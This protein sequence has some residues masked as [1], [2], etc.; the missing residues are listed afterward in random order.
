MGFTKPREP[1]H[2]A[3]EL[4]R[5]APD[6]RLAA[7]CVSWCK[8]G[9]GAPGVVYV[10]YILKLVL[11]IGG[12]LLVVS[13]TEGIGGLGDI[14]SWWDE[15]IVFQKA[16]LWTLA[17]EVLGL[18]CSSGPLTGRYIPPVTAPL[19]FMRPGTTR[20]APFPRI[21]L[22]S[23]ITRTWV[24]VGLY[25]G[26]LVAIGRAL[27]SDELTVSMMLPVIVVWGLLGLRDKTAFLALRAEHYLL[28][29]FVFLFIGDAPIDNILPGSKAI[30]LA[31]WMGAATSKLNHHFPNVIAVMMS[32]NPMLR[33]Q[34]VRRSLYKDFPDD[35]RGSRVS[36]AIAHGATVVE[37]TFP[38]ILAFS[39]GGRLTT[40]A[41]VVMVAFHTII[42]TSFPLGVPLEWNVFF[43]YSAVFLFGANS[44]VRFWE[45][46]SPLLA[47][48]LIVALVVVPVLGNLRPD[49]VSFL[50]SMRYYAGNWATSSWL[51]RDG[52]FD[53]FQEGIVSPVEAPERQLEKLF[54]EEAAGMVSG[55]G[56]FRSMHLHGRALNALLVRALAD[57]DDPDVAE[58]GIDAFDLYDGELV[59]G[60]ALGWNFGDGHL[61][62]ESLVDALQPQ[63][64]FE[65]GQVRCVMIE[66]Q[67]F[68][69]PDLHW[70]IIDPAV[71]LVA[72][73]HVRAADMLEIQPWGGDL[74]IG[75]GR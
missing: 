15:P 74:D 1:D 34:R 63:C 36:A 58:Q 46:D 37:Y 14:G 66:S 39:T 11:Y 13:T 56:A 18:G 5:M 40:V 8:Y 65:P 17:Y 50:P 26:G 3:E 41:L 68:L 2:D 75:E 61:H 28:T 70:R 30:Q 27:F 20:L 62:N 31:L 64:R 29:A 42:L 35:L 9:F 12:F 6:A 19:F 60:L 57:F 16:V 7:Q 10:F 24:D 32:N 55:V 44:E 53:R 43:I 52:G 47:V 33:S 51:F 4:A 38:L 49:K 72:E 67:P 71:G 69:R 48:V 23:G 21:P 22:T 45:I 59:A 25:V 73:G 54:G